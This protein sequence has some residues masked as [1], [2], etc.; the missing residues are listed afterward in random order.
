MRKYCRSG[1]HYEEVVFSLYSENLSF[2]GFLKK[3]QYKKYRIINFLY[4]ELILQI[5][6]GDSVEFDVLALAVLSGLY[7]G[8][9]GTYS[10]ICSDDDGVSLGLSE[11][12]VGISIGVSELGVGVDTYLDEELKSSAITF[13]LVLALANRL[14]VIAEAFKRFDLETIFFLV[15]LEL[16]F[17]RGTG[18]S[19]TSSTSISF[20]FL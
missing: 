13:A 6:K 5:T 16:R 18:F 12:G 9:S 17:L 8:D 7:S 4:M 19:S 14:F 3:N 10:G 15:F 1:L 11:L 2:F 20:A